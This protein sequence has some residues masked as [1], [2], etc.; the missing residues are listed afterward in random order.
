MRHL[1]WSIM[2]RAANHGEHTVICNAQAD[3][4]AIIPSA[5][6]DEKA[7]I[8]FP[9]DRFNARLFRAAPEL[10]TELKVCRD[11]L[12]GCLQL[13]EDKEQWNRIDALIKEIEGTT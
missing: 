1:P 4:L 2:P 12:V 8:P 11:W 9:E 5:A 7:V 3:I 10:L 13:D 6:W